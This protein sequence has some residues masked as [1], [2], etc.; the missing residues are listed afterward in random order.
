MPAVPK[1]S[2]KP[3]EKKKYSTL[4]QKTPLRAKPSSNKSTSATSN[5]K[6]S[7]VN[8]YKKQMLTQHN[9]KPTRKDRAEFPPTVVKELMEESSGLCQCKCGRPDNETHHVMPRT[10]DGRGVKTNGM[11]VNTICNQRFHANEEELQYWISVYR[12]KHGEFFWFDE[13]DWEEHAQREKQQKLREQKEEEL[14]SSYESITN[15]IED[16]LG[17][18]PT[19]EETWLLRKIAAN[20]KNDIKILVELIEKLHAS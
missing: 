13:Q 5:K 14:K 11:R 15:I 9:H 18:K 12:E 8:D 20:N 7:Q 2:S 17:R 10:R 1:P 4:Q 6:I 19:S 3:K 16:S